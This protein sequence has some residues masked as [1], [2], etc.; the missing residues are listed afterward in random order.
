M[1]TTTKTKGLAWL[2][3]LMMLV[4][5]MPGLAFAEGEQPDG[6]TFTASVDGV[7]LDVGTAIE[8]GYKGGYPETTVDLYSLTLSLIHI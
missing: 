8:N 3:S 2:L 4:A 1:K 6:I 7:N 5:L